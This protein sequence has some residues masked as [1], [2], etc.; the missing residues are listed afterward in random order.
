LTPYTASS[1][2]WNEVSGDNMLVAL[3]DC[4]PVCLERS[5]PRLIKFARTGKAKNCF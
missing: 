1:K 4:Y 2:K 3:N 5:K